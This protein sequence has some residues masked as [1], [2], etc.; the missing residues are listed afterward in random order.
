LRTAQCHV[1]LL[2]P[3]QVLEQVAELVRRD[4]PHID[5]QSGMKAQPHARLARRLRRLDELE[6]GGGARQ[7]QRIRGRGDH[8]EVLD[9]LGHAARRTRDLDPLGSGVSLELAHQPLAD[10][11]RPVEH[12]ARTR[13]GGHDRL[14]RLQDG[15][16]CLGAEPLELLDAVLLRRLT[17]GVQGINAE[18]LEETSGTL[19]TESG[20]PCYL[21]QPGRELCAQLHRGRNRPV[22]GERQNLFLNR[23]ADA[24][25]LG[26]ATLPGQ[27]GHRNGRLADSFGRVAISDHPVDDRA[28]EL[29]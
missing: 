10:L 3:R 4:D 26:G 9:R 20:Q 1:V 12:D 29:G 24:R 18:L 19:W 27:R 2:G 25:E 8:V 7:R 28:V 23:A 15:G 11:E 6:V 13:A 21:N 14:K 5:L 16:L 17:Q 22:I